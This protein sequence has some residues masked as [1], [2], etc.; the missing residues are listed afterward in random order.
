M[1]FE[2]LLQES[3]QIIKQFKEFV[4][5]NVHKNLDNVIYF[6]FK[7]GRNIP[8]FLSPIALKDVWLDISG[9]Y[10]HFMSFD[11]VANLLCLNVF[12]N[13]NYNL[14]KSEVIN[15]LE[16]KYFFI[17]IPKNKKYQKGSGIE[18]IHYI[19]LL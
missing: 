12:D 10:P 3:Q 16:E 2:Q 5:K 18:G 19:A 6:E 11:S 4:N 1:Q 15:F 13:K 14:I 8:V 7:D 17:A 9:R